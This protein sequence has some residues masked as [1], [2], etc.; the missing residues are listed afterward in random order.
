[1]PQDDQT[2]SFVP[3]LCP[4]GE[5]QCQYLAELEHLRQLVTNLEKQVRTDALTNLYNFRFFTEMLPLEMERTRRFGQSMALMLVDIDH[6]KRFNDQ[7]GHELGNQALVH[8]AQL[9]NQTVRK[10]DMACRFGGEEF[11]IILPSTDL[12]QA[13]SVAERLR[14]AIE[15]TPVENGTHPISITAS[16]GVDEFKLQHTDTPEALLKRVDT[17]LYSAKNEGRNRVAH[18]EFHTD[19][20]SVS[21]AEKA[22]L[23]GS[24]PDES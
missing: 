15:C 4:V 13:V 1:M 8:V 23:F 24:W 10:L 3:P 2:F 9:I 5:S 11:V 19:I 7:W 18:P 22:A 6:F 17:W 20:L 14:E 21:S 12:A 16:I